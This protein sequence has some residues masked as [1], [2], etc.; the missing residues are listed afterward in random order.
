MV[1]GACAGLLAAVV[2]SSWVRGLAL[3]QLTSRLSGHSEFVYSASALHYNLFSLTASVDGLRISR[4]GS[5]A[6]PILRVRRVDAVL[7]HRVL[8]GVFDVE[9]LDAD[10]VALVITIEPHEDGPAATPAPFTVPAFSIGRAVVRHADVDFIDPAGLG[11][12]TVRDATLELDGSGPR[13]LEG[14]AAVAGGLTLDNPDTHA[15]ID[16]IEGRAFLDGD[17]IGIQLA[18]AVAGA[19]R[20]D[21]DGSVTLTGPSPRFDLGIAGAVDVAQVAAWFPAM[22]AGQGPLR[23]TGRVTGPLGNPQFKYSA[24]ST[25]LALPDIRMPASTA[26]GTISRTGIYVDRLRTGIGTGWV[27]AAG[28]LPLGPGDPNSRF[29][30]RWANVSIASLARVFPLLPV[31]PIGMVA[32]G[33]ARVHW[34]GMALEFATV[35]GNVTSQLRFAPAL[36]P[37]QVRVE[38][39]PGHWTLRGQQE[40]EGG[41]IAD[42]ETAITVSAVDITASP[43]SGTLRVSSAHL[44]PAMAEARL[45][46]PDLPDVSAWLVDSPL[47]IDSAIDGTLG[48]PR[49]T[50]AA[51]SERLQ[52]RDLPAMTAS[53]S[54]VATPSRLEVSK[55]TGRDEDGQPHRGKRRTSSLDAET[56]AGTFT[57][58]I[59]DPQPL[60][61]AFLG[62]A[63]GQQP[64]TR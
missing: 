40:L 32:T 12:L 4:R 28:R 16:R 13:R 42:I 31:D 25:G 35:A 30:L 62:T 44:Q 55:I 17:T 22:P 15:R 51:V 52:L 46:F 48:E 59:G 53:A 63:E 14:R 29:S 1:L 18:S 8:T 43:L 20:L 27:E 36:P 6:A 56:T 34:P 19:Q 60:L 26:E 54:F 41:T 61:D 11:H 23:L 38:A 39:S 57:A 21:L 24:Q 37:A 3:R 5:A 2:H 58:D 9:R 50:G 49:L 45:G 10:G 7:S 33:S 64:T 47:I